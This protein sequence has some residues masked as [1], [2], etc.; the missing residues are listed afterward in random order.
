VGHRHQRRQLR[1]DLKDSYLVDGGYPTKTGIIDYLF[2]N[3]SPYLLIDE[4]DKMSLEI[5]PAQFNGD[6]DH[7]Q[8]EIWKDQRS[9][10]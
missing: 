5:V 7:N 2:K 3:R 9:R 4:I 10:N 8:N 1:Q 6:G